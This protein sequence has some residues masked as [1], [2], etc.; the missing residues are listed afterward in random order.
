LDAVNVA[1]EGMAPEVIAVGETQE[2]L[3]WVLPPE[4]VPEVLRIYNEVFTLPE[5]AYNAR[6]SVI[7]R[8]TAERRYVMRHRGR[9]VMDVES[10]FLTGAIVDEL[11]YTEVIHHAGV[12]DE[13][14]AVDVETVF[15][16][17]LAH[18]D[19]C[20]RE[21]L[22]RRYDGVVRGVT[23]L[24]RGMADAGVLVP[25][26]G[27]PM[28]VALAVAGNPRYGR[29]DAGYAAEEAVLEAMRRV[30]AVG[31]RPIGLTDCLN[32]GNPRKPDQYGEFVAAVD[33][34]AHAAT[35]LD[36]PFVSGNVSF[37][38]ESIAGAAVPA[39]AIV[40]C[41]G[42]L[43]DVATLVTPGLKEAGS[44]LLWIGSRELVVGGSV[45]AELLG[46]EGALPEISYS[47]E[48]AAV[49]IV[50]EAVARGVLRSCRA[51]GN[52]G[53][54]TS[55]AR[56]AFDAMRRGRRLGAEIDFGNPLCEAG[57]F[58]CEVSDDS[59]IDLTRT[60]R[61]G[62]TIDV[63]EL[64]VNGVRFDVATLHRTWSEPLAELY[65]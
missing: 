3:L 20:S 19:V 64:I 45:L 62:T 50:H 30:V 60:L 54:L 4:I 26:P 34:L 28:G 46:I 25:V 63:P 55:V 41:V 16:Q 24:A 9:V 61:I 6:A 32:F 37:Y 2:R 11:P 31:A 12:V 39:S 36:L 33:G 53:M 29:I 1:A 59:G 52:G 47:A 18:R 5:I 48:R 49:A 15:P 56:L 65:P 38:N 44:V 40:A 42:V 17:V 13:L 58:I 8:V 22:Y 21:P 10:D 35:Q 51:I 23:V 27:S 57:G 43:D 14:P 7:G